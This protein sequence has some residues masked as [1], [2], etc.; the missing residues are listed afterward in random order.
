MSSNSFVVLRNLSRRRPFA[1]PL[2][3]SQ[4][5]RCASSF[6]PYEYPLA[7]E[8]PEITRTKAE[9]VEKKPRSWQR[10]TPRLSEDRFDD[11]QVLTPQQIEEIRSEQRRKLNTKLSSAYAITKDVPASIPPNFPADQ[12]E[13]PE[14]VVT[15]L[16]NGIRGETRHNLFAYICGTR[17]TLSQSFSLLPLS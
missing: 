10:P 8:P 15:T 13:V 17:E 12:L 3:K 1:A 4:S 14:T 16:D 6:S 11:A 2:F 7:K 9:E 5:K